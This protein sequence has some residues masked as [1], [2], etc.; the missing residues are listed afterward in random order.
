LQHGAQGGRGQGWRGGPEESRGCAPEG[1]RA[2][3]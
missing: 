3:G 1:R 2:A